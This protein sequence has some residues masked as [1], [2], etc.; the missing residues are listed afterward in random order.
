MSAKIP[1]TGIAAANQVSQT[2]N[3]INANIASTSFFKRFPIGSLN[4]TNTDP[5]TVAFYNNA[6]E[7]LPDSFAISMAPPYSGRLPFR[8]LAHMDDGTN[9][10][11]E[12]EEKKLPVKDNDAPEIR[13]ILVNSRDNTTRSFAVSGGFNDMVGQNAQINLSSRLNGVQTYTENVNDIFITNPKTRFEFDADHEFSGIAHQRF[14]CN[15]RIIDNVKPENPLP[16]IIN[17]D[18]T[19]QDE[20]INVSLNEAFAGKFRGSRPKYLFYMSPTDLRR[21]TVDVTDAEGNYHGINIPVKILPPG[22]IQMRVLQQNNK[23]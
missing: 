12:S 11:I 13:I 16:L 10:Y 15:I 8:V 6:T 2:D 18:E 5:S 1:A 7:R 9:Y 19:N 14:L 3:L 17:I 4:Q 22:Q 23:N 20:Q 21:L